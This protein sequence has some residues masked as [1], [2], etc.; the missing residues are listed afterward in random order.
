MANGNARLRIVASRDGSIRSSVDAMLTAA[1]TLVANVTH[2]LFLP[3]HQMRIVK[4]V[5]T[6]PADAPTKRLGS[7]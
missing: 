7:S 3:A 5:F 2:T 6:M 4:L 1:D